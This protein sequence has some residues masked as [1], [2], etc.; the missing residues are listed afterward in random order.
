[1]TQRVRRVVSYHLTLT[2]YRDGGRGL[3]IVSLGCGP[4]PRRPPSTFAMGH[5]TAS[6]WLFN[7]AGILAEWS[8]LLADTVAQQAQWEADNSRRTPA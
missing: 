4:L 3:A 6:E 2:A 5:Y 1:M 8:D 7:R